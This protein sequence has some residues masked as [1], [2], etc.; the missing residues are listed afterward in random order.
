MLKI[1]GI[2]LNM[3][4]LQA[5]LSGYSDLPMRRVARALGAPFCLNE[6]AWDQH[7]LT[8]GKL[9]RQI[10][11][12]PESD[13][14]VGGQLMG[15][16]PAD[17]ALAAG[18]LVRAGYDL[19][20][21]NFGCPVPKV[22]GRCRGGY[23]LS[24]E[25]LALEIV[26]RIIDT[27][28]GDVPVTVKMRRG[29]DLS[30]EAEKSFF[31]ILE[32][33]YELGVSAVTVHARTVLQRYRGPSDWQF[34]KRVKHRIGDR[35]LLGSGDLFSPFDAQRMIAETGVDGVVFARGCIG[36]P[37]IF[38]QFSDLL[39]GRDPIA[40]DIGAQRRAIEMHCREA[41]AAYGK[42]RWPGRV[43]T[44]AI[45]YAALHPDPVQVRDAY[46]AVRNGGDMIAVL[47]FWYPK[48]RWAEISPF[49]TA[50]SLDVQSLKSCGV[51]GGLL[52]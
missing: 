21:I 28:A 16:V 35:V 46:V 51:A 23:L 10:L 50:G 19:V 31:R 17:L 48:T 42:D 29:I 8:R 24:D 20:D 12:L 9:R 13:H 5:A 27:C 2:E 36:N 25:R 45:K 7:V 44:H 26:A 11:D 52:G 15:S 47:D 4:A 39:A 41:E 38:A 18:E 6:V 1:G 32:G 34:L 14:P 43:R 37:W 40:P 33:A 3:P 49:L 22:L 30:A